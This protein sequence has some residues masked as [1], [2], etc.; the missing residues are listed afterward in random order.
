[1]DDDADGLDDALEDK[2]AEQ[3]A[4][5]V[6]HGEHETNFPVRVDWWLE[7]TQ[8]RTVQNGW[9]KTRTRLALG[10]PLRQGELVGKVA[11][12]AGISI[13]SSGA[14]SR[15]K[16]VSFFLENLSRQALQSEVRPSE[17]ITYVH[18][19]P[20]DLGGV[21]IQYWRAYGW[22]AAH[23]LGLDLGH[24]GDWEAVAVHLNDAHRPVAT[25]YLDHS[26]IVDWGRSVRWEGTHPLVW[27]EEGGHTSNPDSR[28]SRSTRFI[29]DPTW[30]GGSVT[31][32]DGTVIGRSGGLLNIGEKSHPRNGQVFVQYS[33]LWGSPGRLFMTTGYWGPAF[34][35]TGAQCAD[36]RPAYGSYLRRDAQSPSCGR[37]FIRAWCD[38]ANRALFDFNAECFASVDVD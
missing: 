3:F 38:H 36:G 13:S 10:G 12:V 16:R 17:W 23:F 35:E 30:A 1:V 22:N 26:G 15:G 24:G 7:R 21:T 33:G 27:S 6:F 32:W 2:L 18:S 34:N 37:I 20:N 19:Y 29:R 31:R 9:G 8:L 4:P 11:Q 25:T 28:Y 5:V 14:R